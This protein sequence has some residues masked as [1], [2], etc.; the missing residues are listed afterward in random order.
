MGAKSMKK[1]TMQVVA[2]KAGLSV[3]AFHEAVGQSRGEPAILKKERK[4]Q[5]HW[6]PP[7]GDAQRQSRVCPKKI[8]S[9]VAFIS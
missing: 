4:K 3:I 2:Q 7:P 9:M 5:N 8:N 1:K 6:A